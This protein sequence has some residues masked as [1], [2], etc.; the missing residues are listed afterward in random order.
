MGAGGCVSVSRAIDR[1]EDAILNVL[2][3]V[4]YGMAYETALANVSETHG[5]EVGRLLHLVRVWC[6]IANV[7]EPSGGPA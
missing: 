3:R 6:A 7:S 4:D 2:D 1:H 5:I